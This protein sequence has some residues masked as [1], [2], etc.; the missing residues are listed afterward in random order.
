MLD[1]DDLKNRAEA[2]EKLIAKTKAYTENLKTLRGLE[3][4]TMAKRRKYTDAITAA[5]HAIANLNSKEKNYIK[6]M[7]DS[8]KI[9]LSKAK[10]I[11]NLTDQI[12][13]LEKANVVL[14]KDLGKNA[15]EIAKNENEI[16][17]LKDGLKDAADT[18]QD[19]SKSIEKASDKTYE[20]SNAISRMATIQKD[21]DRLGQVDISSQEEF[22]NLV[23]ENIQLLKSKID[24]QSDF[25][26]FSR[27]ESEQYKKQ[28]DTS[29]KI[30]KIRERLLKARVSPQAAGMASDIAKEMGTGK[31]LKEAYR[32]KG[33]KLGEKKL[34]SLFDLLRPHG[35]FKGKI[36]ASESVNEVD[37]QFSNLN[38]V[39]SATGHD[40]KKMSGVM[41]I[42]GQKFQ[43]LSK[44]KLAGWIGLAIQG[45]KMLANT[46]NDLDK[47]LKTYNKAFVTMYGSTVGLR[48]VDKAMTNF[49]DSVFDLKRNLKY[50]LQS[51]EI[52]AMFEGVSGAGMSL[53]G[54]LDNV[55][56]GYN[57]II[58]RAKD[59]HLDFGVSM[60]EAGAMMSEQMMDLRM[61]V[62][63]VSDGFKSMSYDA[64][65][66]G[67][68]SK[69]FYEVTYAAAE[70]LS[71]YGKF[72]D[73]AS[74]MLRKFQVQ[75][76][77]GFKDSQ[78][79]MTDTIT[80][81]KDMDTTSAAGFVAMTGGIEKYREIAAK[82]LKASRKEY[83]K[84]YM[85][86]TEL[87]KQQSEAIQTGDKEEASRLQKQIKVRQKE[88]DTNRRLLTDWES[89]YNSAITGQV[90][91]LAQHMGKFAK[92]TSELIGENM[93][94]MKK[95]GIDIFKGEDAVIV[96]QLKQALKLSEEQARV[97]LN[98]I[99]NS[100]N[101]ID[102]INSSLGESV[103][104]LSDEKRKGVANILDKYI[105]GER[106][107]MDNLREDLKTY[108]RNAN[109]SLNLEEVMTEFE[110]FP[111]A[112]KKLMEK[113]RAAATAEAETTA[114]ESLKPINMTLE[115]DMS[116][117]QKRQED[118]VK[119]MH[120]IE[121]ML[122][123]TKENAKYFLAGS[124]PQKAIA[125]ATISTSM[126]AGAILGTV[127]KWFRF[128][129]GD[130]GAAK[131]PKT[132]EE[133]M[134]TRGREVERMLA[135]EMRLKKEI[136]EESDDKRKAMLK[137]EL[138]A[139]KQ[140]RNKSLKGFET[141]LMPL[142]ENARKT[143]MEEE[144][145]R[146]ERNRINATVHKRMAEKTVSIEDLMGSP[147]GI[148]AAGAVAAQPIQVQD[149]KASSDGIAML[150]R[151][152]VV[153]DGNKF[154]K[155]IMGE[156]GE[157]INTALNK[158]KGN[159][160]MNTVT[161]PV[162][163]SIGS[164]NGDPEQFLRSIQP[165]IEQS[166]ERMFYEKQKRG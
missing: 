25:N 33:E 8:R 88:V 37:K 102:E 159:G 164:V 35:G 119:N 4:G 129:T 94:E 65:L 163:I 147:G 111:V 56:G 57:E 140:E 16:I 6:I 99:R 155:G 75:G 2:T 150:S 74:N 24:T 136:G 47:F 121:E 40:G 137:D 54:L 51:E 139:L 143:L 69:K 135:N 52:M 91:N 80:L 120:T 158:I 10:E 39:M 49:N 130:K 85:A 36:Q 101:A 93:K 105:S 116:E 96:L 98:L 60:G 146:S 122:G 160:A 89:A 50:G 165:A 109:I 14:K 19:Y 128:A 76:G 46:V 41:G 31:T 148:N 162:N 153:V 110:R 112:V 133:F 28:L 84:N 100:K 149:F 127:Q 92:H 113:G 55:Q 81:L 15:V 13:N 132:E 145:K 107:G 117:Q 72:L 151:G 9:I 44:I 63:E 156:R 64:Q 12:N 68:Q 70:S 144:R 32:S 152:D 87:R 38:E 23:N 95:R 77:L 53:K 45:I 27:E 126:K 7:D 5:D 142:T 86:L 66:A 30:L 29:E 73:A 62:D 42:I 58:E 3:Q 34:S 11:K 161:I 79:Q 115:N 83:E 90:Q 166:F 18:F 61:S 17:K 97:Q 124:E 22:N 138:G 43:M 104:S 125:K 108:T 106:K 82:E 134:A 123:I 141:L 131:G 48:D 71:Y 21:I 154:S 1:L 26:E 103:A 118:L 157:F 67:V 59:I 114:F 78:K 20:I